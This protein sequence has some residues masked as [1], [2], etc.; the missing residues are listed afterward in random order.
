MTTTTPLRAIEKHIDEEITNIALMAIQ[1]SGGN[2]HFESTGCEKW[3]SEYGTGWMSELTPADPTDPVYLT[4]KKIVF[5]LLHPDLHLVESEVGKHN[6]FHSD[7][8]LEKAVMRLGEMLE[9]Q[10]MRPREDG[11]L[12]LHRAA[13]TSASIIGWARKFLAQPHGART[14][15][16]R[17]G[18]N[19]DEVPLTGFMETLV[20]DHGAASE[21]PDLVSRVTDA[22]TTHK[23]TLRSTPAGTQLRMQVESQVIRES[24]GLPELRT[25]HLDQDTAAVLAEMLANDC[26]LALASLSEA[27]LGAR[28]VRT[29]RALVQLWSDYTVVEAR[30]LNEAQHGV[31]FASVIVGAAVKAALES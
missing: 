30:A 25:D 28:S 2:D 1:A 12:D 26:N 8:T 3:R 19:Q 5:L 27:V 4:R 23:R 14:V 10:V 22:L 9:W 24:Y 29:H 18:G 17:I 13:S 21:D 11:G 20:D 7:V 16:Q 31:V 6:R 15:L